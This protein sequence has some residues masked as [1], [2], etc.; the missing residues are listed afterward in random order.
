MTQKEYITPN[1][2]V[3]QTKLGTLLTGSDVTTPEELSSDTYDST[4]DE[5]LSRGSMWDDEDY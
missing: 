5:I 2:R 1:I 4:T 3:I